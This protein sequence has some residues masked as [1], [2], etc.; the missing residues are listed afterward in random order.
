MTEFIDVSSS[1]EIPPGRMKSFD[2]KGRMI[3]VYHTASGFFASDNICPHRGGPL[4]QG[5]LI[6]NEVTC[7]WHLW[8]FDVRDGECPG[9]R[10]IKLETFEVKVENDRVMVKI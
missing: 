9:N 2:I 3:A 1:F 5:D 4:T 10:E 6:G 7:P 8:S